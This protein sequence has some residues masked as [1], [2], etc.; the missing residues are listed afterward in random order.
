[1]DG[2]ISEERD[3]EISEEM[4]GEISEEVEWKGRNIGIQ[5]YNK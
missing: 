2:E 5:E 1:M 4:D 3:G